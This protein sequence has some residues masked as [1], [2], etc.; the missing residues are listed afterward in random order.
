MKFFSLVFP[1]SP[2]SSLAFISW[3]LKYSCS[4]FLCLIILTSEIFRIYFY[5]GFFL[6]NFAHGALFFLYAQFCVLDMYL[7]NY[8]NDLT[9]PSFLFPI[10]ALEFILKSKSELSMYHPAV[11]IIK[12]LFILL[13]LYM[14]MLPKV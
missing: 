10:Y 12:T 2:L 8:G 4:W 5:W 3:T 11:F 7:K 13:K 1:V 14:N 9:K 6:L